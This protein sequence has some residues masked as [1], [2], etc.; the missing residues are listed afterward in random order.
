MRHGA[1]ARFALGGGTGHVGE[2]VSGTDF[3]DTVSGGGLALD[4]A[5]GGSLSPVF[6][7]GGNLAFQQLSKPTLKTN[8]GLETQAR[9]DVNVGVVGVMFE[10]FAS[11]TSGFHFG[12]TLGVGVVTVSTD[13]GD[14][15]DR[16]RGLGYVLEVGYDLPVSRTWYIGLG[17]R[18]IGAHTSGTG[19]TLDARAFSVMADVL[20]F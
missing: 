15:V 3:S 10:G 16:S 4:I 1:Y 7:I 2:T 14:T 8:V 5:V 9:Y 6:T 12:G 18:Y 20:N 11:A 17:A 13:D 19:F